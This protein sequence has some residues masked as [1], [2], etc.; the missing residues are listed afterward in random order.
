MYCHP[1]SL[2]L[3]FQIAGGKLKRPRTPKPNV[4]VGVALVVVA[5]IGA[6]RVVGIVVPIAAA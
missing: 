3:D 5:T 4:A 1:A 2:Q 6:A